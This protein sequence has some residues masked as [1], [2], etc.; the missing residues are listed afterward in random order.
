MDQMN[1]RAEVK[2]AVGIVVASHAPI[3]DALARA[4][5]EIT[6]HDGVLVVVDL[7]RGDDAHASFERV[8]AAVAEADVGFG[9]LLLADLFGG[10]AANIALAQ[11]D[12]ASVEV[13]TGLNLAML[14][15]AIEG[16]RAKK[17][18]RVLAERCADAAR[19]SVVVA[20]ELLDSR[21]RSGERRLEA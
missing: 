12:R 4:A 20:A 6:G 16:Q 13:V 17:P 14:L 10:S 5:L 9:V 19:A 2:P 8:R 7:T 21:A 18:V 15:E 11:L 1:P 3:G